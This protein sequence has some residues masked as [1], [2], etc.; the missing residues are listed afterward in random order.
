MGNGTPYTRE[1]H[2]V[3]AYRESNCGSYKKGSAGQSRRC[4]Q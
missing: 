3:G 1:G 2:P 4:L